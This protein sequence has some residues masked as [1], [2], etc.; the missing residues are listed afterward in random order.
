MARP[1]RPEAGHVETRVSS[2]GRESTLT[3]RSI[4]RGSLVAL[5]VALGLIITAG[6]VSAAETSGSDSG[7]EVS[8]SSSVQ[9]D[10]SIGDALLIE[11]PAPGS[12]PADE[13]TGIPQSVDA[14]APELRHG[15]AVSAA[16][17]EIG[18]ASC[19][20]SGGVWG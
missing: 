15:D 8:S 6:A 9:S 10:A 20:A 13:L 4:I 17:F 16:P 3:Y 2:N 5:G 7:G 1:A 12:N 19:R 14:P 18:R 11:R